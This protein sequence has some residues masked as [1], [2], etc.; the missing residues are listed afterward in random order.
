MRN[1]LVETYRGCKIFYRT[2]KRRPYRVQVP[3]R[4][5]QA[6]EF[7]DRASLESARVFVDQCLARVNLE[8]R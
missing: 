2:L 8:E 6:G 1:K 5:G 4:K 3:G 7:A